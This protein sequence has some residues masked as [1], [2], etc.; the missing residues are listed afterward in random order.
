[1]FRFLYSPYPRTKEAIQDI[2]RK[3]EEIYFKPNLA[4]FF[5]TGDLINNAE[6]FAGLVDCNSVC[7]PVEGYITPESIWTRCKAG[8]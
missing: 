7:M 8:C 2:R 3:L 6:K 1:M 4:I 5:L